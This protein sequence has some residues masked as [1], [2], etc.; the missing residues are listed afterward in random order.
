MLQSYSSDTHLHRQ[1]IAYGTA[2]STAEISVINTLK[3]SEEESDREVHASEVSQE[4]E[5]LMLEAESE[6]SPG[7]YSQENNEE[8]KRSKKL[9]SQISGGYISDDEVTE[10]LALE[11][12]YEE[13]TEETLDINIS[14]IDGG[15]CSICGT[16][17]HSSA[18]DTSNHNTII[19]QHINSEEHKS[20]NVLHKEFEAK[21]ELYMTQ[22]REWEEE[23]HEWESLEDSISDALEPL[24]H[25]VKEEL[26][27]YED[28]LNGLQRNYQWKE[29]TKALL[30]FTDM[31]HKLLER[32]REEYIC[33]TKKGTNTSEPAADK[34]DE[35]ETNDH[36]ELSEEGLSD[37]EG[38]Q[39]SPRKIRRQKIKS[40]RQKIK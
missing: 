25:D 27:K 29:G 21:V 26:K 40:K 1:D 3:G 22:K 18:S 36:E 11:E 34:N 28:T 14:E 6:T 12:E 16:A 2:K 31:I 33:S 37:I 9:E 39:D 20:K 10:A 19:K 24:C 7:L 30:E 8:V 4:D 35:K 13:T 38:D 5:S 32:G 15:F 23:V 17:L